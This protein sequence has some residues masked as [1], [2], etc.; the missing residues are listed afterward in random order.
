MVAGLPGEGATSLDAPCCAVTIARGDV[1]ENS[2][3]F[4][5]SISAIWCLEVLLRRC[6]S[7]VVLLKET[8]SKFGA[9]WLVVAFGLLALF[10]VASAASATPCDIKNSASPF[11][12]HDLTNSFCELHFYGYSTIIDTS[13]FAACT[14][15][16]PWGDTY[17]RYAN[18]TVSLGGKI[19]T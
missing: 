7:R 19:W 5:K 2:F 1:V 13:D 3:L 10:L 8:R 9:S 16:C 6:R 15:D 11:I 4:N 18:T 12:R 14:G 17:E